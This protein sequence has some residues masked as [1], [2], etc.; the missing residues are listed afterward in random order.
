MQVMYRW[1]MFVFCFIS[2]RQTV[3]DKVFSVH[4]IDTAVVMN[5]LD[6]SGNTAVHYSPTFMNEMYKYIEI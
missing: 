6:H 5:A 1:S 4:T 2:M 3:I